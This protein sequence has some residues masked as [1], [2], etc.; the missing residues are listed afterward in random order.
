[1]TPALRTTALAAS[2]LVAGAAAAQ[3]AAAFDT[4]EGMAGFAV[5]HCLSPDPASAPDLAAMEAAGLTPDTVGDGAAVLY[6]E[7][8]VLDMAYGDGMLACELRLP[9]DGDAVF[10]ARARALSAA[11]G[12]TF[13][14]VD[15]ETV[16]D[17]MIW[18]L[19]PAEGLTATAEW[20]DDGISQ[21]FTS[22]L[23]PGAPMENSE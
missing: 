23:E 16:E 10:E 3:D 20:R 4:A 8:A 1:M 6:S 9:A 7:V 11:I 18:R 13:E 2:I 21:L 14:V 17:G 5:A 15:L 19:A 22:I 12:G